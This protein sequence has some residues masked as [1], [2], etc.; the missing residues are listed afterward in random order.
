MISLCL[1]L[2]TLGIQPVDKTK[3]RKTPSFTKW[4]G[5]AQNARTTVNKYKRD[6]QST[7]YEA[8]RKIGSRRACTLKS[9]LVFP[10][11]PVIYNR[12]YS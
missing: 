12:Q 7:K 6:T 4:V 10:L 5:I 2:G 11:Q 3:K 1:E 9:E 8:L